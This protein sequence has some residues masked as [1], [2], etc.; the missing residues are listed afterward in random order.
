[1]QHEER[2]TRDVTL[3]P[4]SM[5]INGRFRGHEYIL[6]D[7]ILLNF[8]KFLESSTSEAVMISVSKCGMCHRKFLF[9]TNQFCD[10]PLLSI[11]KYVCHRN[12]HRSRRWTGRSDLRYSKGN[13][14]FPLQ[15]QYTETQDKPRNLA[16][17]FG[18]M[19]A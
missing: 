13:S 11:V 10:G 18:C 4:F 14:L 7:Y 12:D 6:Y 16:H 9:S 5:Y 8:L 19:F 17:D 3:G 1:M 2:A 15:N